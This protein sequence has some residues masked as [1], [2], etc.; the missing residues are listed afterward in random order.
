MIQTVQYGDPKLA[1]LF[2]QSSGKYNI[3]IGLTSEDVKS[4][5]RIICRELYAQDLYNKYSGHSGSSDKILIS[6]DLV[7]DGEYSV[8]ATI[9]DMK[10][11]LI[12]C[13]EINTGTPIYVSF[14]DFIGELD[15]L[16]NDPFFKIILLKESHGVYYGSNRVY[17]EIAYFDKLQE[18]HANNEWFDV[19]IT[20]LVKGGYRALYKNY[21]RCFIPGSHAAANIVTDFN[22][23]I[24]KTIPVMIDSYDQMSKLFIVSYKKYITHS[25]PVMIHNLEFGKM[26][27][28]TLTSKPTR[29]GLFVEIEN[30][31]TGLVHATE[32]PN[33][34][35]VSL[36]VKRGDSI[37]VYI[38]DI[39][40]RDDQYRI[41]FTLKEE[42]T[43]DE[44]L[45]WKKLKETC[46]NKALDYHY[47]HDVKKF[48]IVT[49]E[50]G[51][52]GLSLNYNDVKDKLDDFSHVII[53]DV[54]VIHQ[55][56][57]FDFC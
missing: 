15:E 33:Y 13:D 9:I 3:S 22:L 44:K 16:N 42:N 30:Y 34:E 48:Y 38:K 41:I 45:Y 14:A 32:F 23:L 21:I 35:E 2:E 36:K 50:L 10:S 6:K 31:F 55:N 8:R 40:Y 1:H 20:E 12:K 46:L 53:K 43:N 4:N 5:T 54:D 57:K 17:S 28:G 27:K 7:I 19:K 11:K 37:D 26:Y 18:M 25:L 52:I 56:I 51:E 24:G 39:Q 49:D 29:Y 47:D